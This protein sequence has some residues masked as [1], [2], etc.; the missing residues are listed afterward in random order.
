MIKTTVRNSKSHRITGH[1]YNY[2]RDYDPKLGRY[3]Q[4]DP[5]G[6]NGGLN[7]YRYVGQSPLMYTDPT[8][9]AICENCGGF[10]GGLGGSYCIDCYKKS[11]DPKGGI[12]PEKR[13]NP[14]DPFGPLLPK[15]G[16][17]GLIC[18]DTTVT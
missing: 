15:P 2:F 1:H 16:D 14:I 13:I 7:R 11:K 4:A 12:L 3:M 8:G 9:E 5:I 17:Q 10:H 18:Q 6:L